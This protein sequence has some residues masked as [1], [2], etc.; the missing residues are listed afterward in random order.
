MKKDRYICFA[1]L[2]ETTQLYR[3]AYERFFKSLR[4][5]NTVLRLK[6]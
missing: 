2:I 3:I 1:L 5:R 4:N 6:R